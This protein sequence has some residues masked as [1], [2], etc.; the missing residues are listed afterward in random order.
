MRMNRHVSI[1]SL[2]LYAS[3]PTPDYIL[4]LGICAMLL[5]AVAAT[6]F[7][8]GAQPQD[9]KQAALDDFVAARMLTSKCPSWQLDQAGVQRRFFELGLKPADWQTGGQYSRIFDS[10]LSYYAS[11]LSRMSE[12]TACEAAE[13]AFGPA[14]RVRQNWMIRQ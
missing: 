9:P 11:L 7:P 6:L 3:R 8:V 1:P 5:L 10:R 4:M 12:K 2:R 13:A 14:G